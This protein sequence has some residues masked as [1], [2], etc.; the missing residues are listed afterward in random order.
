MLT[1]SGSSCLLCS[2]TL[3]VSPIFLLDRVIGSENLRTAYSSTAS[4]DWT[5]LS[6]GGMGFGSL[7]RGLNQDTWAGIE[8]ATSVYEGW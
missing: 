5:S 6:L 4:L 8:Q 7:D 1:R 2:L 3:S